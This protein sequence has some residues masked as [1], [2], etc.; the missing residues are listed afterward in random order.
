[1]NDKKTDGRINNG[2][3][4]TKG[5]AGRKKEG[6]VA[7]TIYIMPDT[8]EKLRSISEREKTSISKVIDAWAELL[9][10]KK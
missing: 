6:L 4:S 8:D 2:G 9:E 7:K 5:F 1:M 10:N 3:H